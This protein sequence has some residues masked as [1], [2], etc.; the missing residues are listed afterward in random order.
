MLQQVEHQVILH[1]TKSLHSLL[2]KEV[3]F[4]APGIRYE[5]KGG[6]SYAPQHVCVGHITR[7]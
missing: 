6:M 2:H 4:N 1:W 7:V 5:L 3:Q